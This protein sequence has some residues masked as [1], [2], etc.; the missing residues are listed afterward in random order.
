[1]I[2]T[3]YC[4]CTLI[5]LIGEQIGVELDILK[6]QVTELQNQQS[7]TLPERIKKQTTILNLHQRNTSS[8]SVD[9]E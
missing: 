3:V 5:K 2:F 4:N 7:K 8:V 9:T 6:Q 1:M